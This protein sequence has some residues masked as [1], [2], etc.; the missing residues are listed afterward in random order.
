MTEVNFPKSF[1]M[2]SKKPPV[3]CNSFISRFRSDNS[4]YTTN[5]SGSTD[6]IRISIPCGGRGQYLMPNDSFLTFKLTPTITSLQT[7][8]VKIDGCA[9]SLFRRC[10]VLHGSTVLVDINNCG[11]L[12]NAIRDV[13]VP[14][15]ARIRDESCLLAD[16]DTATGT[17]A[18]NYLAGVTFPTTPQVFDTAFVLPVGLVGSLSKGA[19]PICLMSGGDLIIELELNPANVC[20]TSRS[21]ANPDGAAGANTTPN[22]SVSIVLSDIYYSAKIVELQDPYQS[23]LLQAYSKM[24]IML[25]AVDYVADAKVISSGSSVIN[26]KLAISRSSCNAVFWWFSNSTVANGTFTAFNLADGVTH[27]QGC[28]LDNYTVQVSG[29][30]LLDIK[31][32]VGATGY[33]LASQPLMQLHRVFNQA[34]Q[35]GLGVL[36]LGVYANATDTYAGAIA[37][38]KRFVGSYSLE[39]YDADNGFQSG[40]NLIGQDVRLVVNLTSATTESQNLYVFGMSDVAYEIRDGLV[41]L[42]A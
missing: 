6:T 15:S 28:A 19:V 29:N 34:Q 37:N 27:R 14:S 23:L 8:A 5:T 31:S 25:P 12:W 1:D 7:G 22:F 24:P 20:C 30:N 13:Q 3:P 40:M 9:Y 10:R 11:R 39:R 38:T 36:G 16:A 32:G 2:S 21:F 42:R 35:D 41:Y 26:E 33:F 18:N 17:N 4:T